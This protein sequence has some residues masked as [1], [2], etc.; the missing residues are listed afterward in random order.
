MKAAVII[1]LIALPAIMAELTIQI[2]TTPM[3]IAKVE[4][5]R[6]AGEDSTTTDASMFGQAGEV[7]QCLDNNKA[8]TESCDD[9]KLKYLKV[10]EFYF[11]Q[12]TTDPRPMRLTTD[13]GFL[14]VCHTSSCVLTW[15]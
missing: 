9:S 13:L 5:K 3:F 6:K 7:A 4:G 12:D 11:E 15:G 14:D 2:V 10:G 1:Q 8:W